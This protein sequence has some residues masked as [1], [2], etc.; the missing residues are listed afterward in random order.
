M[1]IEGGLFIPGTGVLCFE[2]FKLGVEVGMDNVV[3][4][5]TESSPGC[6]FKFG[7]SL[8]TGLLLIR[9]L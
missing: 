2:G 6:S 9:C 8:H 7:L 3:L 1:V 4:E 5:R